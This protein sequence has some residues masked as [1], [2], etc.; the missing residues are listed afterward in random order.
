MQNNDPDILC[1][2]TRRIDSSLAHATNAAIC[3]NPLDVDDFTRRRFHL[4]CRMYGT[5]LRKLEQLAPAAFIGNQLQCLPRMIASTYSPGNNGFMPSLEPLFSAGSFNSGNDGHRFRTFLESGCDLSLA[6]SKHWQAMV[7]DARR[8]LSFQLEQDDTHMDEFKQLPNTWLLSSPTESAG[9]I[10][11]PGLPPMIPPKP[12]K[13]LTIERESALFEYVQDEVATF[14]VDDE[15][16]SAFQSLDDI[17]T[18]FIGTWSSRGPFIDNNAL[19]ISYA[20]YFGLPC[21]PFSNLVGRQFPGLYGKNK[22]HE[23]LDEYGTKLLTLPLDGARKTLHDNLKW[24][25]TSFAERV[26]AD[27]RSEVLDLFAPHIAQYRE[28]VQET[29]QRKRQG[30][31]PDFLHDHSGIRTL[32]DLKTMAGTSYYKAQAL[33]NARTRCEAVQIRARAVNT[34][35]VLNARIIDAK[36][37]DVPRHVFDANGVRKD[38]GQVGPVWQRLKNYG[39]VQGLVIGQRS[40]CSRDLHELLK[41]LASIGGQREW[42]QMG[43]SDPIEAA[44]VLLQEFKL[45]LG[46]AATRGWALVKLDRLRHF[47]SPDS[48]SASERRRSDRAK[49]RSS[50]DAYYARNGPDAFTG[51]RSRPHF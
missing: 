40:E 36:F 9:V 43:A 28:F 8:H 6:F 32:M 45:S 51:F 20:D 21:P 37:N 15:R 19:S 4:P 23:Y 48:S 17:S 16:R 22:T 11:V 44:A 7:A 5:G 29:T 46:V 26:H 30:M 41:K 49:H 18:K 3:I 35:C 13:Q 27:F 38:S 12:Q 47:Y 24:L 10:I 31:I 33:R 1:P 2:F 42:R 50:A 39:R 34:D 14:P 25:I